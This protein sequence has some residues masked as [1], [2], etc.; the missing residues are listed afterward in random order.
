MGILTSLE[1]DQ[2]MPVL[3][4]EK[5]PLDIMRRTSILTFISGAHALGNNLSNDLVCYEWHQGLN[6]IHDWFLQEEDIVEEFPEASK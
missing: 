6:H 4:R 5:S 3:E 2:S 1:K